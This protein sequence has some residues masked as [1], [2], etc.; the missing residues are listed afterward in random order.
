MATHTGCFARIAELEAMVEYAKTK[1]LEITESHED[2]GPA[3]ADEAID[4]LNNFS[5]LEKET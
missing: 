5:G 4:K 2:E 3:I 1:F